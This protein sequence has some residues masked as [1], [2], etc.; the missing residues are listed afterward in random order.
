MRIGLLTGRDS[1]GELQQT[2]STESNAGPG[3]LP[4]VAPVHALREAFGLLS[5]RHASRLGS[6]VFKQLGLAVPQPAEK[7][8]KMKCT[9]A[10]AAR[11]G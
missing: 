2:A 7:R 3:H 1:S 5:R 9:T 10:G 8:G 11:E 4:F 6:H